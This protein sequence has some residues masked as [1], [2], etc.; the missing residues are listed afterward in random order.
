MDARRDGCVPG[1]NVSGFAQ[2]RLRR[3]ER[4]EELSDPAPG[5]VQGLR[6]RRGLARLVASHFDRSS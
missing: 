2:G 6:D 5:L 3:G 1:L 4:L